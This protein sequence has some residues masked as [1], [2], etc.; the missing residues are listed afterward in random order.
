VLAVAKSPE[1][2]MQQD[3]STPIASLAQWWLDFGVT[4]KATKR[5]CMTFT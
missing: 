1:D 3:D 4:R 5:N 2:K